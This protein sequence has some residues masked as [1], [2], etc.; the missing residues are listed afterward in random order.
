MSCW[1]AR[2][3]PPAEVEE[4]L[5]RLT[6]GR[7]LVSPAKFNE[8]EDGRA[9][10]SASI[11]LGR[12]GKQDNMGRAIAHSATNQSNQLCLSGRASNSNIVCCLAKSTPSRPYKGCVCLGSAPNR[13]QPGPSGLVFF[14][15][16]RQYI[17][18]P[19]TTR[20]MWPSLSLVKW[21]EYGNAPKG[22]ET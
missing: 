19:T 4:F 14:I 1:Q 11:L 17:D 12:A 7:P 6:S 15:F 18:R 8:D 21:A 3:A 16:V 13:N 22:P 5:L 9:A 10:A 20:T 2:D